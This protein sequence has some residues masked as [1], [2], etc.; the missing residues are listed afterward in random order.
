MSAPRR[1]LA[2]LL[3]ALAVLQLSRA[4]LRAEEPGSS[5]AE[6]VAPA[7]PAN[8]MPAM[9]YTQMASMMGMDDTEATARVLAEQWEWREAAR[10][11]EG[12]WELQGWYGNDRDKLW[13]RSEGDWVSGAGAQARA[14]MFWDRIVS[15]WWSLQTGARYDVGDGPGRGW[16]ALG[17]Q[18]LAPYWFDLAL[19][20]YLGDA[21]ALATRL[22]AETDLRLAQRWILQPEVELNAYDRPD[23]LRLQGSGVTDTDA[24]LRLRYELRREFAPY[25]GVAWQRQ[26]GETAQLMRAAARSP[27]AVQWLLG[28]RFW[29]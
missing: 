25:L 24:G 28:V 1:R 8:P 7:A 13:I 3:P 14:E 17:L 27:G 5:A 9:G 20:A 26:W 11:P 4:A 18:G 2:A 21:G 10:A 22:H 12:V 16:A 15:R 19:T 29:L 23:R 6:H